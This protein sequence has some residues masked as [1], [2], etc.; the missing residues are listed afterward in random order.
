MRFIIFLNRFEKDTS[1]LAKKI[2]GL[3][4]KIIEDNGK[5]LIVDAG[6]AE[7][8]VSLSEAGWVAQP[9]SGWEVMRGFDFSGVKENVLAAMKESG[10]EGYAIRTKF[11]DKTK[12]SSKNVYK[13][14]NPFLKKEGFHFDEKS[15]VIIYVEF[16]RDENKVLCRVSYSKDLLQKKLSAAGVD[17][18]CFAVAIEN[19]S[20]ADEVSDF[21]RL[22]WIFKMP[23]YVVTKD[24]DFG[25]V[26]SKAKE[27]TKGIVY[28]QMKLEVVEQMPKGYVLVGFSKLA[29]QNESELKQFILGK[30][31]KVCLVFG[32]D[33]F[34]LT[35]E[36]RD[37]MDFM[38]RLTP[39]TKKP[40]RA[41][42][43]LSY[44]L[45]IYTSMRI[46]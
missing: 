21:L 24:K 7:G 26:M 31:E 6:S 40:M 19:P 28:E 35:Q 39:E 4:G 20:L 44:V 15:G 11:H 3:G 22:C 10:A 45:G 1:V 32:D 43:A 36:A 46:S 9:V 17:Y 5:E 8:L 34:G 23:L 30:K 37:R 2:S 13:H 27:I 14:L 29:S 38:F 42:H 33:K 41:S 18:S 12:F 25:K 16:K